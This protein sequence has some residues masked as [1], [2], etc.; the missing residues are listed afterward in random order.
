MCVFPHAH[1]G[2][3]NAPAATHPCGPL[4]ASPRPLRQGHSKRSDNN[5]HAYSSVY[6]SR[7]VGVGAQFLPVAGFQEAY[8]NNTCVLGEAAGEVY[9][10]PFQDAFPP[11]AQVA[12]A[13]EFQARFLSGG[14]TIYAPN[15]TTRGL[16][17]FKSFQDF[18]AS[19]WELAPSTVSGDMPSAEQLVAWGRALLAA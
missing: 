12:N 4:P 17:P 11:H 6:G 19:G 3:L 14:N 7:C 2:S 13:S 9:G 15:A 1:G 18:A 8:I 10:L 16:G 5:L